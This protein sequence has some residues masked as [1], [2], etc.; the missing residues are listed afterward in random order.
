VSDSGRQPNGETD[1]RTFDEEQRPLFESDDAPD[2]TRQRTPGAQ[3]APPAEPAAETGEGGP[4]VG[5]A[6]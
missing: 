4:G 6:G 1:G 5:G 2:K 3:S